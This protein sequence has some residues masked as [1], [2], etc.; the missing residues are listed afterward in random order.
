MKIK[1]TP[2]Y[3]GFF[4]TRPCDDDRET[5][6]ADHRRYHDALAAAQLL[7][8]ELGTTVEPQPAPL[9]EGGAQ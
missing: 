5:I 2:H 6:L 1:I 3:N 7:A 4:V 9:L 8:R